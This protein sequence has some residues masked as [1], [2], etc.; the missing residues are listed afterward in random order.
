[1]PALNA[2]PQEVVPGPRLSRV[3]S[4][5]E[6]SA[7]LGF[8]ASVILKQV[9]HSDRRFY[10]WWLLVGRYDQDALVVPYKYTGEDTIRC[11]LPE[12]SELSAAALQ[13]YL[14][15]FL[16]SEGTEEGEPVVVKGVGR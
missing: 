5:L 2:I 15:E 3:T 11:D 4:D 10:A 16:K 7:P 1:M 8:Q 12:G 14:A 9:A 6:L 13:P